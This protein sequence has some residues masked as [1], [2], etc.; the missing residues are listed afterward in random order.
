M[1]NPARQLKKVMGNEKHTSDTAETITISAHI[2]KERFIRKPE[3]MARFALSNSG[4]YQKIAEGQF[5]K[6]IHPYGKKVS[7]WLESDLHQHMA[8]QLQSVGREV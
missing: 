8:Q 3:V 5:P 2:K 7:I 1:E 4:L 6:P